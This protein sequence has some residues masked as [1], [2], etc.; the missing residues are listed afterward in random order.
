MTSLQTFSEDDGEQAY[1][2]RVIREEQGVGLISRRCN[3]QLLDVDHVLQLQMLDHDVGDQTRGLQH[4][5]L[6]GRVWVSTRMTSSYN[7]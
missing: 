3:P 4:Q 2:D 1:G 6:V 7:G 5:F